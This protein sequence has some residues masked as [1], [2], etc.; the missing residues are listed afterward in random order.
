MR[1]LVPLAHLWILAGLGVAQS[2]NT[3]YLTVTAIVTKNNNSAFECWQL[4]EPFRR[5]SVPGISGTQ[6]VTISNNTNLAYTILP[7]RFDGGLHN[8]PA[9]QIVHFL[10][11]LA[12]LT[13]P[14]NDTE[15]WVV[16]G[17][18]G[19]LFAVDTTGTGHRTQYPSDQ[20]TIAF[21]APFAEGKI[22][23]HKVLFDGPCS[24]E[25]TFT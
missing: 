17:V 2:T 8:A 20:E 10:S 6:I 13:L 23:D 3:T 12:Y 9:P 1:F 14:H 24:G 4:T 11:G 18:G 15:A 19:L 5:S 22:P 16:G 21:T 25:Q 7:P